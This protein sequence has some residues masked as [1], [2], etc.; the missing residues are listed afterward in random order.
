[1]AL[2]DEAAIAETQ[3][4]VAALPPALATPLLRSGRARLQAELAHQAGDDAGAR[5]F[6]DE[7]IS[8]LRAMGTRALLV[9]TL[10]ERARRRHDRDALAEAR[11]IC[12]ELKA[13]RWLERIDELS[14]VPAA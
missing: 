9:R 1:V 8:L 6:E 13:A 12:E 4:F 14:G 11:G 10:L 3:A 2:G 7:A 5:E